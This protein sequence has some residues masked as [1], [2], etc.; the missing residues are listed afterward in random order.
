MSFANRQSRRKSF[1]IVGHA[2]ELTFSCYHRYPFL[3]SDRCCQWLKEAIEKARERQDFWLWAFVFM[4]DHAHLVVYPRGE[5]HD[6]A[7]IFETIKRPVGTKA[8]AHLKAIDSP[9]LAKLTRQRGR[10]N[11]R[12]FW[13]SGGGYDRNITSPKTLL[14]MID[15]FA[16][17]SGA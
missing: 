4:P 10:R 5:Q 8:I 9:W 17:K 2:H 14:R 7:R 11:E 15:Y 3:R 12:L 16:R 6:M 1:N 13:Q